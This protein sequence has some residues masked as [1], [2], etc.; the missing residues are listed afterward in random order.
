MTQSTTASYTYSVIDI[1]KV[2]SS[3]AADFDMARATTGLIP[4]DTLA[5]DLIAD[6]TAFAEA[7]LVA[8]VDIV[9]LDHMGRTL[10]AARYTPGTDAAG[11]DIDRPGG[12][13]W[14]RTPTGRLEV[15]VKNN[16]AWS[17]LGT[18]G[19]RRFAA[20]DLRL[21]WQPSGINLSH[22]GLTQVADRRYAS[23]SYGMARTSFTR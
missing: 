23:N 4:D 10:R 2:A 21:S 22:P 16:Q 17:D 11:W 1:R 20:D 19:Q 9:L 15:V 13:V 12:C 8:S 5:D 7:Q 3:L 18:A 6:V 14:P